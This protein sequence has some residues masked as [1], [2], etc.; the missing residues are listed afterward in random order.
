L[1]LGRDVHLS[2]AARHP[3]CPRRPHLLQPPRGARPTGPAP[4]LFW[5]DAVSIP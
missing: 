3:S 4:R 5:R 1:P 2:P